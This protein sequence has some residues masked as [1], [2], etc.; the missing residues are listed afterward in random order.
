MCICVLSSV[1]HPV[2]LFSVP[3][4]GRYSA[5]PF[6]SAFV[7]KLHQ[8]ANSR[9]SLSH[10]HTEVGVFSR[11]TEQMKFASQGATVSGRAWVCLDL[12]WLEENEVKC[13]F[14]LWPEE[15]VCSLLVCISVG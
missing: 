7:C 15:S 13:V 8:A 10:T 11:I 1:I 6:S 3:V 12:M 5:T 14:P 2:L 9:T 4:S